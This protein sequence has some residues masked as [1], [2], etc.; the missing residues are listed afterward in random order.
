MCFSVAVNVAHELKQNVTYI[1]TNG[2]ICAN[3][4]LQMLLEKTVNTAEQ[5]GHR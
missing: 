1:D 5:V 3:R 4:L 2:G